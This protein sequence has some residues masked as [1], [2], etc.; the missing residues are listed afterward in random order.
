MGGEAMP[1]SWKVSNPVSERV[2]F[3]GLLTSGQRTVSGLCREFGICRTTAYKYIRRFEAEGLEGLKERSRAPHVQAQQTPREIRELLVDARK[4]HPTWGPRKL[5]AWLEDRDPT[6]DLPYASTIG[7]ILKKEG[8][9]HPRRRRSRPPY[10]SAGPSV[11]TRPNQEWNADFKGE[12]RLGNGEYCFPL[13]VTDAFSRYLLQVRALPST[14]EVGARSAF[15]RTFREYGLPDAIRTD[16][17]IPFAGHGLARLTKLS[18]WWIRLGIRLVRGRPHH[19]QDNGRHERMHRTLKAETTRPPACESGGQQKIF[20]AFIKE[21]NHERPHEALGQVPPSRCYKTSTRPY[22]FKL[23]ELEY[24][25]HYEV[26]KVS[27]IGNFRWRGAVVFTTRGLA[28]EDIGLV[29]IE[30]GLWRMYFSGLDLG[31]LD[32]A[33]LKGRQRC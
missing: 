29:E 14:A 8:L 9:V 25:S 24:P 5:K 32:E 7:D 11:V 19:P 1:M 16:N 31:V 4:D 23:P 10:P 21:Y 6:L 2:K 30:D 26:R 13:T 18:V 27:S 17:G 33:K 3:M 22:P 12:F 20:N 15:E 28:G